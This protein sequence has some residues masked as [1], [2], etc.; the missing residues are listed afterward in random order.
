MQNP[1]LYGKDWQSEGEHNGKLGEYKAHLPLHT[2]QKTLTCRAVIQ[3][4]ENKNGDWKE[5]FYTRL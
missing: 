2:H 5:D 3:W 1:T 4:N